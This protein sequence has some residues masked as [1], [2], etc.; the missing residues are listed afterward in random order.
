M[1]DLP[2]QNV[3]SWGKFHQYELFLLT[4]PLTLVVLD[5]LGNLLDVLRGVLYSCCQYAF[6]FA[7]HFLRFIVIA[8]TLRIITSFLHTIILNKTKHISFKTGNIS[9]EVQHFYLQINRCL[10]ACAD[11]K[12]TFLL[13]S[14]LLFLLGMVVF[15]KYSTLNSFAS[16][17]RTIFS[18]K[19]CFT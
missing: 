8:F 5:I 15:I 14:L 1:K 10:V 2:V 17:Y 18:L 9:F 11:L 7:D 16:S 6:K 3:E 12:F 13:E 19:Q 4:A